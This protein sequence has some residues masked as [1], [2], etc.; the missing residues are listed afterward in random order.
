MYLA[1]QTVGNLLTE[2]AALAAPTSRLAIDFVAGAEP[3]QQ[4][5]RVLAAAN[6]TLYSFE[7]APL[8][9]ELHPGQVPRYLTDCGWTTTDVLTRPE[10]QA[11][12]LADTK[13]LVPRSIPGAY[14][15]SA[16]RR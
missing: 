13:L 5:W 15:V 10:M 9:C 6:R 4:I 1:E 3:H 12:F 8:R 14:V 11:R 7:G 2:M 16:E